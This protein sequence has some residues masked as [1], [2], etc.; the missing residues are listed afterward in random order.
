MVPH[1]QAEEELGEALAATGDTA[2]ACAEYE[3]VIDLWGRAKPRSVTAER[4][5]EQ[6][7]RLGCTK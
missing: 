1:V 7:R 2:G 5:R 3:S 6:A 4:A